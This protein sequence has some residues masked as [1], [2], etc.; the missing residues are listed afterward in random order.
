MTHEQARQR[1]ETI[2]ARVVW[3]DGQS[4][5]LVRRRIIPSLAGAWADYVCTFTMRR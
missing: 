1:F 2:T 4:A 3:G 5:G